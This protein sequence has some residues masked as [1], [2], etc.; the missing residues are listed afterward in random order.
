M[1]NKVFWEDPYK[2]ELK[3]IVTRINGNEIEL[4]QTIIY[5]ESG[6]QESDAGTVANIPVLNA[7]KCEKGIIYTLA[8]TPEFSVG[9]EVMTSIDWPRRYALMKLH[10]AAEVILVLFTQL[11]PS[12]DKIGAHISQD[13]SRIDFA[14]SEN[15]A[16]LLDNIESKAQ[17]LID[18]DF[19][20]KSAFL[21]ENQERRYWKVEGF[22]QVPCGGT[23]LKQTSEVGT[24]KLKRKNLGKGKERVE[25]TLASIS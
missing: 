17:H 3:A 20:I 1:T 24:I 11:H 15:I 13:K 7:R 6:G 10:F 14:W 23:H 19:A 5:A 21:D 8:A 2:T 4:S 12:I 9:D 25:I 16:A 18:A 22:A